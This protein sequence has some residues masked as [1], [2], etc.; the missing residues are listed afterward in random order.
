MPK[1]H[2]DSF[3]WKKKIE[4]EEAI[5]TKTIES[6]RQIHRFIES[7]RDLYKL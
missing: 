7:D 4:I 6:Y 3:R 1:L 2:D 5:D